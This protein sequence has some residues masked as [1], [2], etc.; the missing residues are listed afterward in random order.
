MTN[1]ST[2]LNNRY[3]LIESLGVGGMAEVYRARDLML[4]RYVAIKILRDENAGDQEFQERFR[5]EAKAAAN[6]KV[7]NRNAA[8]QYALQL[9]T[10]K[11]QLDENRKQL[12]A[13]ESTYKK[14][15]K[16]RDVAV[17]EA[18]EAKAV[19]RAAHGV[20]P[21]PEDVV[22][23]VA[24]ALPA[25]DFEAVIA[26]NRHHVACMAGRFE[27]ALRH[28]QRG[29]QL[30]HEEMHVLDLVERALEAA[31]AG[32]PGT[33]AAEHWGAATGDDYARAVGAGWTRVECGSTRNA[34]WRLP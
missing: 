25:P 3:Q 10:V 9:K 6:L 17:Q 28:A 4:E 23:Q 34:F 19:D 8:G 14:L 31:A 20:V 33:C 13:A 12:E 16:S 21:V 26:L 29:E 24:R 27:D 30:L 2:L 15:V 5:Q 11:E 7:G 22:E 32:G 18:R 1:P